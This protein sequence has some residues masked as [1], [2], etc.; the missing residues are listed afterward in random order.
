MIDRIETY[1]EATFRVSQ[2]KQAR[3][4]GETGRKFARE[5]IFG[6]ETATTKTEKRNIQIL[7]YASGVQ[8]ISR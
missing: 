6:P 3:Q 4:Q 2:G 8:E 5:K 1:P 7:R